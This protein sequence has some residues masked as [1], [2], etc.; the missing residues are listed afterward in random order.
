MKRRTIQMFLVCALS[1]GTVFG[2][3][4]VGDLINDFSLFDSE[5]HQ[6]NLYDYKGKAI[7]INLWTAT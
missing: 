6:V 1:V 2:A 5:G 4:Q 3:Y 7:F